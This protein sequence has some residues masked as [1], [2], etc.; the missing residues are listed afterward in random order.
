MRCARSLEPWT[1]G[2]LLAATLI[3]LLRAAPGFRPGIGEDG[4]QYLSMAANAVEGRIGY[5]SIVHYDAERS[6]GRIPSP[7]VT[8]PP[9]YP[10]V[11]AAVS[12]TGMSLETSAL[13]VS[14]VSTVVCIPLMAQMLRQS[15]VSPPIVR[16]VTAVFVIN[17][18]VIR[19]GTRVMTEPLFMFL[20]LLGVACML[21]ARRARSQ[22]L[23]VGAWVAA[24]LAFGTAYL[25]RHSGFF[26]IA[27]LVL[28]LIW[29][30][31]RQRWNLVRGLA[32]SL[33][34]AGLF[35]AA[36][37]ARNLA[38]TGTY[39]G[40]DEMRLDSSVGWAMTQLARS[41]TDLLLGSDTAEMTPGGT[42]WLKAV[43]AGSMAAGLVFLWRYRRSSGASWRIRPADAS[44]LDVALLVGVYV[45]ALFLVGLTSSISFGA[46]RHLLPL[47]PI[48]LVL[49]GMVA[50]R[51]DEGA[52]P[53][54]CMHRL[55]WASLGVSF[56]CYAYLN[57]LVLRLPAEG[58][59]ADVAAQLDTADNAGRSARAAVGDLVGRDGVIL[60]SNGQAIGYAT[61]LRTISIAPPSFSTTRW[62][63]AQVRATVERFGVGAVVVT[64]KAGAELGGDGLPSPFLGELAAERPP[65]WLKLHH[66][67]PRTLIYR[68]DRSVST[69]RP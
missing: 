64:T 3:L 40:R 4:F 30:G 13:L 46:P 42:F 17:S 24:G 11:V 6:F 9:G 51:L 38:L 43:F 34:T 36:G 54:L 56:G 18:L 21:Q 20:A 22:S 25:V 63:E 50:Q 62:D 2:L 28:L 7:V 37:M 48:A 41:I 65:S 33:A 57:A 14:I 55:A 67:T 5:T 52:A 68:P 23:A 29:H 32:I 53:L 31:V 59:R 66:R 35:V 47:M 26:F 1:W 12:L 49:L 58:P 39:L 15:R 45:G 8:F 19:Y 61:G 10:A 60:A 27:G 69:D 44:I 16:A